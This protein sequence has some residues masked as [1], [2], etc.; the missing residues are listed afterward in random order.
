MPPKDIDRILHSSDLNCQKSSSLL[1]ALIIIMYEEQWARFKT[2]HKKS[3]SKVIQGK[4]YRNM[5][6]KRKFSFTRQEFYRLVT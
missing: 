6:G 1:D 2:A 4:H 5:T 3:S